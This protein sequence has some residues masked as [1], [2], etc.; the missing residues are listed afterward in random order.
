V[1]KALSNQI[2]N[3]KLYVHIDG[4]RVVVGGAGVVQKSEIIKGK[5]NN[6]KLSE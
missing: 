6:I 2:R 4:A 3:H 5:T 1:F